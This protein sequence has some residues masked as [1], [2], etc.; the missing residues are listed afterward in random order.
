MWTYL[1]VGILS[2][3]FLIFLVLRLTAPFMGFRAW[4][5]PTHVPA[6]ITQVVQSL[7]QNHP[8][9]KEYLLA[10]YTLV[11][12]RYWA[13]RMQ[14]VWYAPLAFRTNL[15]EIWNAPGY[16]HCNTQNYLLF[17]L[18]TTSSLFR[19]EDIQMKTV[20]FNFFIHQHL[21]V[22]IGAE[23]ISADPAGATIRKL[24]LGA[25]IQWFG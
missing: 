1:L 18:L 21:R 7:E 9:Q 20:F 6:N 8:T 22:K 25:H 16:A 10:A 24:P 23:W 12:E 14:T 2:Y 17:T 3:F 19:P 15:E 11:A 5:K 13:G 4:G